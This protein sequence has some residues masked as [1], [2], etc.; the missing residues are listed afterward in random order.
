[1]SVFGLGSIAGRRRLAFL[2][3]LTAVLATYSNHFRN[4][5]HF[6]DTYSVKENPAIRDVSAIPKFFVDPNLFSAAAAQRMYRPVTSA[7]LAIDYWL[8]GR[9]N[10]FFFHLSTFVWFEVQL[11]LMVLFFLRIM[12][13]ADPHPSNFWTALAAT[14]V[15][16]LHPAAAE[17]L[18]YI[19]Q[20]ADLYNALGCLASLWLFVRYPSQRRFGWYLLPAVIAML[21]KPPAVVFPLLLLA[22]SLLFEQD[23]AL[24]V[25]PWA[26][27]RRKWGGALLSTIPAFAVTAAVASLLLRMRVSSWFNNVPSP[28]L[29]RLTQ[30]WVAL[31]YFKTFFLP[32][33]LNV[34]PGWRYVAGPF[35]PEALAGY[36]FI[37]GLVI[38]AIAASRNRTSKP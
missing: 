18:N 25:V 2:L 10:P 36:M 22:Y 37:L 12:D 28:S 35:S 7:S 13:S 24:A 8:G 21:A 4:D 16:G 1:M 17:T 23:G 15:F 31:H 29:Y 33:G 11:V 9:L 6:D 32:T 38:A 14:A 20:R 19:I 34:D 5:F 27:Q 30:P 3:L 26:V